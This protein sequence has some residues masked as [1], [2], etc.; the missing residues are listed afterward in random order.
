MVS[1]LV[2]NYRCNSTLYWDEPYDSKKNFNKNKKRLGKDW[3]Y[4]DKDT[5]KLNY[6]F[7]NQGYREQP[8]EN[9][10]W[11]DAIVLLGDSIVEGIGNCLEDTIG[12]Y[13]EKI[14]NMSTVNLGASGTAIDF[15]CVNSLILN[16]E[17]INP[18]A[19]V[20]LWTGLDRYTD[21]KSNNTTDS[22]LPTNKMYFS[23]YNWKERSINYVKA[24]R[25]IWKDKT[26][27][28]EASFFEETAKTL[29][30]PELTKI[31]YARDGIHPGYRSNLLAANTI[32]EYLINKGLE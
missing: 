14:L 22:Y 12:K 16:E 7:N 18:K 28:L 19:I 23:K 8:F 17:C 15:S 2:R 31:D 13:L 4:F 10:K 27:Y 25:A 30:I 6:S 21:F 3:Y 5:T 24:D 1:L 9:V 26:V 11:Q 32:A 20:Q 29:N